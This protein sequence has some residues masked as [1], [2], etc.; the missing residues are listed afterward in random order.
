MVSQTAS[1]IASANQPGSD[2][3]LSNLP[4]CRFNGGRVGVGIGDLVLDLEAAGLTLD[5]AALTAALRHDAS[6]RVPERSL[7][8]QTEVSCELPFAVGDY[9]DFYASIHH[10][11]NVGKL[12]RPEEPLLPNYRHL[13][14]AYHGRASSIVVSGTPVKRP[15]GQL[16]PGQFGPT[17]RLDYELELGMWVG[18]GNVLGR[19]VESAGALS[20]LAGF[21]LVNDWSARDIQRWE[22]QP[23][24]PFLGKSFATT[25]SPWVITREAL[26]PYAVPVDDRPETLPYLRPAGVQF[27]I[28]LEAWVNGER[29]SRS[30]V[31]DLYWTPAQM[32][33]HH[34]SNGCNLRA[35]DL[36][37]SGTVSGPDPEARGCLLEQGGGYLQDGD[38]VVLRG[39]AGGDGRPR[40]GFGECRGRVVS[41][42]GSDGTMTSAG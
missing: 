3:P 18:A 24:G 21:C 5:R 26:E 6:V 10:A 35:G 39:Y 34:T 25:I 13:P 33:A 12:F 9:T 27:D 22:Y 29:R 20:H 38:E 32:V 17:Q 14:V 36:L 15:S 1:W 11:T 2:F 23:L 41:G 16:G 4:W 42:G 7:L 19:P 8:R 30:H 31:R 40:I 37:A 28:V